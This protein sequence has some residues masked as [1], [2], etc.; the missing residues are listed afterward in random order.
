MEAA[1]KEYRPKAKL[2]K[3]D[4]WKSLGL[5]S[6]GLELHEALEEGV[7]YKVYMSGPV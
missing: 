5:P 7:P 2:R 6:R 3:K 1:I 4:F